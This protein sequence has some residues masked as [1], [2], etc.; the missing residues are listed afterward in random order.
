M[1]ELRN[2]QLLQIGKLIG[3][4]GDGWCMDIHKDKCLL[5]NSYSADT[6][7][8]VIP[9]SVKISLKVMVAQMW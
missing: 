9:Q 3:L 4:I 6:T 7:T 5:D 1:P 2:N 8:Q